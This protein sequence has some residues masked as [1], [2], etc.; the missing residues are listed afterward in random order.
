MDDRGLVVVDIV[1][2]KEKEWIFWGGVSYDYESPVSLTS[3]FPWWLEILYNPDDATS[4]SP[5]EAS[6]ALLCWV[7]IEASKCG[8]ITK[9]SVWG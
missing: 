3:V 9:I 6:K 8:G 2:L 7:Y 5:T 1:S 4:F